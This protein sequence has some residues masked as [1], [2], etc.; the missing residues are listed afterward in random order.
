MDKVHDYDLSE[1]PT[2]EELYETRCLKTP[3]SGKM[4]LKEDPGDKMC[5]P[6]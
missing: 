3:H 6:R 4:P 2:V 5:D 1:L